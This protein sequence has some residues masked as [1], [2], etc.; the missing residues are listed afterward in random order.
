MKEVISRRSGFLEAANRYECQTYCF[1]SLDKRTELRGDTIED[2]TALKK[3]KMNITEWKGTSYF[4]A[5]NRSPVKSGLFWL[6][7]PIRSTIR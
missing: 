4:E 5:K 6:P 2:S 1:T 7:T 3:S